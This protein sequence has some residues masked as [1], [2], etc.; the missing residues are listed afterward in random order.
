MKGGSDI[1]HFLEHKRIA[2]ELHNVEYFNIVV[3]TYPLGSIWFWNIFRNMFQQTIMPV[4][5]LH[6]VC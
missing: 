6:T 1:V 5:S 3:K 2:A 4:Q